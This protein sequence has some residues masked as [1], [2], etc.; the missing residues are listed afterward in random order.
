[1]KRAYQRRFQLNVKVPRC[2]LVEFGAESCVLWI[3]WLPVRYNEYRL[4][5]ERQLKLNKKTNTSDM[6]FGNVPA[7]SKIH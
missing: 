1:M 4:E 5:K 6:N 3:V 2:S 7:E